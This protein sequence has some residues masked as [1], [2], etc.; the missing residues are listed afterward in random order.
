MPFGEP[1]TEKGLAAQLLVYDAGESGRC[2]TIRMV[3]TLS[4]KRERN[5]EKNIKIP[6]RKK[7][8]SKKFETNPNKQKHNGRLLFGKS[9]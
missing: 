8:V 4:S 1:I 7:R 9:E 3:D 6:R 2:Q 5:S